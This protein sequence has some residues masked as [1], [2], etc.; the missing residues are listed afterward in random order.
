M[1]LVTLN[2]SNPK[3]SLIEC[4]VIYLRILSEDYIITKPLTKEVIDSFSKEKTNEKKKIIE[5]NR[6][7]IIKENAKN[8]MIIYILIF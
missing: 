2:N 3:E 7:K 5:S 8:S 1:K 6:L 4:Y